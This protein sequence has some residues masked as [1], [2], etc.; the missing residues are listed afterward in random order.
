MRNEIGA[1]SLKIVFASHTPEF[2]VFKVG[3]HHLSHEL[4][5]RGHRVLHVSSPVS[6]A[7]FVRLSNETVRQRLAASARGIVRQESNYAWSVPH[8][9][10][11]NSARTASSSLPLRSALTGGAR[12]AR[13]FLG[14]SP[15]VVLIDQ[16]SMA[17]YGEILCARRVVVRSTDVVT[18]AA[19]IRAYRTALSRADGIIGTSQLALDQLELLSPRRLPTLMLPNG[20]D[21]HLFGASTREW[22]ERR[23]FVYVG[24]LDDRFDWAWLA[25]GASSFPDERFDIWGPVPTGVK[26]PPL[27]TNVSLLGTVDYSEVPDLLSTYRVGLLP[28]KNAPENAGRSPMKLYEYLASGL[29]VVSTS[30]ESLPTGRLRDSVFA[31]QFGKNP[32][33]QLDRALNMID[34]HV[35]GELLRPASWQ[36]RADEL[37]DFLN[38]VLK[39]R[40]TSP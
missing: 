14:G 28:L 16:P 1:R 8:L 10:L 6:L 7:H 9:L 20:V 13:R 32:T 19:E 4:A 5:R 27:P 15:D 40:V 26:V 33:V 3:S 38:T 36:A 17:R 21:T 34:H 31:V 25:H 30:I 24:A 29:T 22:H 18:S 23:G 35:S 12:Q 37:E 39:H 2:S 11:P